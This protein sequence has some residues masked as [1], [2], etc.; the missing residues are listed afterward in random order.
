M[1]YVSSN[2]HQALASRGFASHVFLVGK[3]RAVLN[4]LYCCFGNPLCGENDHNLVTAFFG[5]I[6]V[7]S[8]A[9]E[10]NYPSCDSV[11]AGK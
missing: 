7:L 8:T 2:L 4:R 6:I 10:W 3:I 1:S 11:S 5:I 9:K